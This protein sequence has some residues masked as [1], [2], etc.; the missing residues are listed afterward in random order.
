MAPSKQAFVEMH[1]ASLLPLLLFLFVGLFR[2]CRNRLGLN[3]GS[4]K[5]L[6]GIH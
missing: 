6:D 3:D 2:L 5:V 4:E 1:S